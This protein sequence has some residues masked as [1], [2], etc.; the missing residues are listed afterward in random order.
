MLVT[1]ALAQRAHK[2][3]GKNF[4]DTN[5]TFKDKDSHISIRTMSDELVLVYKGNHLATPTSHMQNKVLQ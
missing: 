1:G 4:K 5:E 2:H 3:Y